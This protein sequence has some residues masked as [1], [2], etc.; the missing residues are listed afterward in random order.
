M[1]RSKKKVKIENWK[2][3]TTN[4]LFKVNPKVSQ[5]LFLLSSFLFFFEN[6]TTN[7]ELFFR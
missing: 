7:I 6:L 3:K 1:S 2:L 4:F 5:V